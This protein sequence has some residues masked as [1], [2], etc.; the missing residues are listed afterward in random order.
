V[1]VCPSQLRVSFRERER[2]SICGAYNSTSPAI[3]TSF[4]VASVVSSILRASLRSFL[5]LSETATQSERPSTTTLVL[6]IG[7]FDSLTPNL[8]PRRR[9]TLH[10][11][12]DRQD[13]TEQL[14]ERVSAR[15]HVRKD[16]IVRSRKR[17]IKRVVRLTLSVDG[18]CC[19]E[20]RKGKLVTPRYLKRVRLPCRY[21]ASAGYRDPRTTWRG[22][23]RREKGCG[24]IEASAHAEEIT[25]GR[26]RSSSRVLKNPTTSIVKKRLMVV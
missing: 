4:V 15:D 20:R 8:S 7:F 9:E 21:R 24:S 22:R 2:A 16:C 26:I 12:R 25:V 19:G 5:F 11:D 10:S 1:P 18:V 13:T 3:C 14:V 17:G 23:K 6:T